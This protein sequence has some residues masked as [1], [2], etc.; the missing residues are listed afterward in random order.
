MDELVEGMKNY[1]VEDIIEG[2]NNYSIN[3]QVIPTLDNPIT[4]DQLKKKMSLGLELPYGR[5]IL[6]PKPKEKKSMVNYIRIIMI[7][8][9]FILALGFGVIKFF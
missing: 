4:E 5:A 7:I 8:L 9:F 2:M 3:Y 1:N 6:L